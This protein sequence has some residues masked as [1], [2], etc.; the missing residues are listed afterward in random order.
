MK[1]HAKAPLTRIPTSTCGFCTHKHT[2]RNTNLDF[3]PVTC[4]CCSCWCFSKRDLA[5]GVHLYL[6]PCFLCLYW[7]WGR[8]W[9]GRL[10]KWN[11]QFHLGE[12]GWEGLSPSPSSLPRSALLCFVCLQEYPASES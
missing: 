12:V 3:T 2:E 9:Q 6:V 11:R 10:R 1:R 8:A 7:Y 4:C 5:V